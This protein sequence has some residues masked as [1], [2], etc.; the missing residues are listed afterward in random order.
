[1]TLLRCSC[2]AL[3][4]LLLRSRHTLASLVANAEVVLRTAV[5]LLGCLREPFNGCSIVW[6]AANC[7]DEVQVSQV[8]LRLCVMLLTRLRVPRSGRIQV[9]GHVVRVI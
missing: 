7:T 4:G 2:I 5:A 8:I 9:D 6:S 3:H 1:M